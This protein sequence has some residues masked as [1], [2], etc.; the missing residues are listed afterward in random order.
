MLKGRSYLLETISDISAQKK[1]EDDINKAKG[2]LEL[3]VKE[4]TEE[5][6][7]KNIEMERFVYAVS[8]D[9]RT[10]LISISGFFGFLKQ[11]MEKGDM[12]RIESDIQIIS[13][14][15][16]K[17]DK[18]LGET[19]ELSRIGRVI[20]PPQ[21]VPF[22]DIVRDSL[23][24]I[25]EKIKSKGI[26]VSIAPDMPIVRVD[27]TRVVEVLVNLLENSIKYMGSQEMREIVIGQR[28]KG[29]ERIFFVID[30]DIGVDA[31]QSEKV[32]ELFYKVDKKSEGTGAG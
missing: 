6:S 14:S 30:N 20:D 16:A 11:D 24:Q 2:Q 3:R 4:R 17:M 27:R 7:R 12:K 19:L 22:E 5:L 32:F 25:Q 1:A 21:D 15:V 31:T 18:L 26:R 28:I 13:D 8:H 23:G 29:A 10:P 9:L